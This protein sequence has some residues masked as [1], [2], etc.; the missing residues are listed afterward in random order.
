[1]SEHNADRNDTPSQGTWRRSLRRLHRVHG[2]PG[3]NKELS[4]TTSRGSAYLIDQFMDRV[5]TAIKNRVVAMLSEF[6][7]TFLFMFIGIGGTS[8]VSNDAASQMQWAHGNLLASPSKLLFIAVSWS[9]AIIINAWIFFRVSGGLFNP[10][11]TLAL[12]VV[13]GVDIISGLLDIASQI[14]GAI[15]ASAIIY[16]LTPPGSLAPTILGEHTSVTQGLFIEMILTAQLVLAVFM[17]ATEKHKA[18][19]IAPVGI[20]LTVFADVLA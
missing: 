11:V 3:N 15:C 20:G 16:A 18:T 5:P 12:M 10:A 17:L 7:G 13:R 8:A 1:M 4:L 19:F 14:G 6:V 2:L 9:M